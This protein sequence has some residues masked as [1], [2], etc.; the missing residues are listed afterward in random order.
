M[1]AHHVTLTDSMEDHRTSDGTWNHH[2]S[3]L[4]DD[5]DMV[6]EFTE[7]SINDVEK[8]EHSSKQEQPKRRYAAE[9]ESKISMS[10]FHY[11]KPYKH[12]ELIQDIEHP[13]PSVGS[14]LTEK[15]DLTKSLRQRQ[16]MS[17]YLQSIRSSTIC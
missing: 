16:Q 12:T 14:N 10:S 7:G 8:I 1:S 15:L 4:V 11:I 6:D 13:N 5:Y 3:V 17:S 2:P 9:E